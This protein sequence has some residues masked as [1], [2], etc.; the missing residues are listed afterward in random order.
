M[1]SRRR[2]LASAEPA[3][4]PSDR[5]AAPAPAAKA[6]RSLKPAKSSRLA[7]PAK[8]S[9]QAA[10]ASVW[11]RVARPDA[12]DFRDRSY[13]PSVATVPPLSLMPEPG[14]PVENQG[15]TNACT[16]FALATVVN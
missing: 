5:K 15:E 3:A 9:A 7:K 16:G 8:K 10:P 1:A 14:L 13:Q 12:I 4:S 11:K 6:A 2:P